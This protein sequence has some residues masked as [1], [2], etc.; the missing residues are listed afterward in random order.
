MKKT[1][2]PS[3][4]KK[5]GDLRKRLEE[6]QGELA[7][8]KKFRKSK[9]RDLFVRQLVGEH[10]YVKRQLSKLLSSPSFSK[11]VT[12]R[13]KQ[14]RLTLANRQRSIKM[15]RTW[16]YF[17]AVQQNYYPNMSLRELRSLFK[18][19]KEGLETDVSDIAWRNPSP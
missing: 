10:S 8:I 5:A 2:A 7:A 18:K 14:R 11:P 1:P 3:S 19:H 6:L 4:S 12:K 15:K 9:Q 17:R 16:D 13:Q